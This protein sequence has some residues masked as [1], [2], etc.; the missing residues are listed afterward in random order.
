MDL[1][2]LERAV[3]DAVEGNTLRPALASI[4]AGDVPDEFARA[5]KTLAEREKPEGWQSILAAK[6]EGWH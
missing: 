1:I 6:M 2:A 5:A 3:R 4:A